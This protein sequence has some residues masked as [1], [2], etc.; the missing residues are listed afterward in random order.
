MEEE[1]L[2]TV[3]EA[4]QRLGVRDTAVRNAMYQ[5]RLP[6][7][8]KYGRKLIKP[9]HL[10]AYKQRAHPGG[11]KPVGRPKRAQPAEQPP[12]A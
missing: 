1:E 11:Q 12:Q 4:A 10:E 6:F 9:S 5:G 3:Q 8:E 7:V 2:L